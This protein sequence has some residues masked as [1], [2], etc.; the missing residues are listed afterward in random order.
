MISRQCIHAKTGRLSYR[1]LDTFGISVEDT[2]RLVAAS[3]NALHGNLQNYL[4]KVYLPLV[5]QH[6][7]GK[8]NTAL[9]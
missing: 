8:Y 4:V 1:D 2:H 7:S 9:S 5:L 6:A 3:L